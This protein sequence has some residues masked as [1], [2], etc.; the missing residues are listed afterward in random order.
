MF[1]VNRNE[2]FASLL[3][4]KVK[5]KVQRFLCKHNIMCAPIN[6]FYGISSPGP[7]WSTESLIF[8][9]P[10]EE[11]STQKNYVRHL[12]TACLEMEISVLQVGR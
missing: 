6:C 8:F 7:Y 1:G 3:L 4:L 12:V 11:T 10:A 2:F 5:V 9:P